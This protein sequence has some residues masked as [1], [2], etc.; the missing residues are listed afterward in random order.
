VFA[1]FRIGISRFIVLVMLGLI[2][3]TESHWL[4]AAPLIAYLLSALG[5]VLVGIGSIGRMWSNL[6]IVGYKNAALLRVGPYSITRN[7]LYFFSAIGGIG[8]GLTT[9]TLGFAALVAAAFAIAYPS[10]I[11]SEEKRLQGIYGTAWDEYVRCVP[12]FFPRLSLLDE[13]DTYT[14]YP[15]LFRRHLLDALWF[16]WAAALVLMIG[17]MHQSDW[18]PEYFS[19]F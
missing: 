11:R 3:V 17:Q 2:A 5:L 6:Y 8:V 7:P 19:V 12:R 18:L 15:R 1:R 10:V 13:P 4:N 16:P 9:G 14:A